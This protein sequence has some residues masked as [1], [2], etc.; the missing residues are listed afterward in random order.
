[1]EIIPCVAL[2]YDEDEKAYL[3]T[4]EHLFTGK[5]LSYFGNGQK[6]MENNYQQGVLHGESYLWYL[7]GKVW[8]KS[9]YK[10]GNRIGLFVTYFENG[11]K[12]TETL[13]GMNEKILSEKQWNESGEIIR[14]VNY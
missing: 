1:M 12:E 8:L 6:M 13:Y 14:E 10:R 9:Q 4:P 3:N 2:K 5:C 7:N 11:S